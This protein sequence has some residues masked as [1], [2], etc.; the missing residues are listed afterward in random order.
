MKNVILAILIIILLI[1][2]GP[3]VGQRG[4]ICDKEYHPARSWVEIRMNFDS[5]GDFIGVTPIPHNDPEQFILYLCYTSE[6]GKSHKTSISTY[7]TL[8]HETHVG[9]RFESTETG[10]IINF[11]KGLLNVFM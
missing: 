11:L 4:N 5:D 6:N 8:W 3:E 1:S 10:I 2:C 9:A 7:E